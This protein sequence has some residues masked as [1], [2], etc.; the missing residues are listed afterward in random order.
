MKLG[1]IE[2][3]GTKFVVCI[4]NEKGEALKASP[5]SL[6]VRS[7]FL[8]FAYL[9]TILLPPRHILNLLRHRMQF[10]PLMFR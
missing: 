2:A 3:G 10:T 8:R 5:H 9:G 6:E 7:Q 1:A 4:G